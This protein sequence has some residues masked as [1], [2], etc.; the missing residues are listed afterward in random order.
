MP[1]TLS[2]L[3]ID[4][5]TAT[6]PARDLA[7]AWINT[8]LATSQEE[9]RPI[10]C[11]TLSLEFFDNG[12]QLICTDGTVLIRSW[13]PRGEGFRWP[14]HRSKP[15][16]T[17]LVRDPDGFGLAFMRAL[18]RVTGEDEHEGEE[19]ALTVQLQ[20]ED[21]SLALGAAFMSKR[22]VL[23][24]CGQR[25]DLQLSEEKYP[26]W[27]HLA[28]GVDDAERVDGLRLATRLFQII[29]K[30]K[31]VSAVDLEFFGEERRVEFVASNANV[32]GLLMPMR[33]LEEKKKEEPEPEPEKQEDWTDTAPVRVDSDAEQEIRASIEAGG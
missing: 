6:V 2:A 13:V 32:R 5:A 18:V 31:G 30:L 16:A 11:R 8:F 9:S 4:L 21:A 1:D 26:G 23:R 14:A 17:V 20:D 12:V 27:R 10:L 19:I 7:V 25:I 28:F 24:S 29:G 33:R 15:N 3:D 22:L